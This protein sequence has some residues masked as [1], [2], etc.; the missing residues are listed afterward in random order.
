MWNCWPRLPHR[1]NILV[2]I[3]TKPWTSEADQPPGH[4]FQEEVVPTIKIA[5]KILQADAGEIASDSAH[6]VAYHRGLGIPLHSTSSTPLTAIDNEIIGIFSHDIYAKSNLAIVANGTSHEELSKWVDM[7]FGDSKDSTR[8]SDPQALRTVPSKYHGGEERIA[9]ASGN[10]IV[11][12]LPGSGSFTG[13]AYKPEISVLA[14][15]LGGETSIKW[16]P[17]FSL[18][19]QATKDF[20][21]AHTKTLHSTYSDA[22][23]LQI[24]I[25]GHA[26][27]VRLAS[28]EVA[29]LLRSLAAGNFSEDDF[30][31]AVAAAKFKALDSAYTTGEGIELAGSA[32][33]QSGKSY[34]IDEIVK[35]IE[36]VKGEQ[37]KEVNARIIR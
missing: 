3:S 8:L 10:N 31:R 13:T 35:R 36:G 37:L 34:Q 26:F 2:Y 16:S 32:L 11:I 30:K 33:V 21:L 25:S 14:E 23:L 1:R 28:F 24:S 6:S 12:A 15:L 7:F 29:K 27:Q 9:H 4:E 22:G 20:P 5:H 17:G 18:V 19:A